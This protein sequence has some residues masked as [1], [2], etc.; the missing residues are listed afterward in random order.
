MKAVQVSQPGTAHR[1]PLSDAPAGYHL[2]DARTA[3]KVV[4][5]P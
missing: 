2:F 3:A 5:F 1:L 4:L